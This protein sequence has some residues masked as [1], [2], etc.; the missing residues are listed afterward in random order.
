MKSSTKAILIASL[1]GLVGIGGLAKA[2]RAGQ[3]PFAVMA[4]RSGEMTK[5]EKNDSMS[6]QSEPQESAKLQSLAKITLQQAQQSAEAALG[7]KASSVKLESENG[8]LVY[9][10]I[11]GQKEVAVDAGNG[12]VLYTND[13]KSETNE[14]NQPRSSIQVSQADTG[15]GDGETNDDG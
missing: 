10:A 9:S 5:G 8:N 6:E 4:E 3:T 12:K 14:K 11:V 2:V 1:I 15:D 7:G 13:G